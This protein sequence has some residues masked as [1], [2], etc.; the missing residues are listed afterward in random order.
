MRVLA[1]VAFAGV[2]IAAC[3]APLQRQPVSS[4]D[5]LHLTGRLDG[6]QISVSVGEPAVLLGACDFQR[7]EDVELCIAARTVDGETFGLVLQNPD[8]LDPGETAAVRASCPDG[9]CDGVAL[10]Q[11]RRGDD[12]QQ[13]D[14]GELV[15]EESGPRY[16]ARF[17]LRVGNDVLNGAFDVDPGRRP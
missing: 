16:A 14:G 9:D 1:V 17:T 13:A 4:D 12:R 6:R 7:P 10:V 2:A 8:D 5:G 11:I 3:G 15:V